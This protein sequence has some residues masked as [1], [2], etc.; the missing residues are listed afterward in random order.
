MSNWEKNTRWKQNKQI[1]YTYLENLPDI[2][3][4][5]TENIFYYGG[6]TLATFFFYL[7]IL[8][9]SNLALFIHEKIFKA[10]RSFW[11]YALITSPGFAINVNSY[12]FI[13]YSNIKTWHIYFLIV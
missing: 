9:L 8:Y 5:E 1:I 11:Y 10:K 6:V 4:K 13:F 2:K 7:T 3:N 12:T